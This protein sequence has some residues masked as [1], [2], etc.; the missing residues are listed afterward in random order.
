MQKTL[1]ITTLSL[2]MGLILVPTTVIADTAAEQSQSQKGSA[3][4]KTKTVVGPYG[5]VTTV[6]ESEVSLEQEQKQKIVYVEKDKVEKEALVHK[7]VDTAL[8]TKS[9]TTAVGTIVSGAG[10]FVIKLKKK[11]GK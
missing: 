10:A 9:V 4:C 3:K 5:Q 6:C 1:A 8:D 7:P 11:I 2:L